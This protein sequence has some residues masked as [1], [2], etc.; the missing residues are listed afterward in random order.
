MLIEL[1]KCHSFFTS[2]AGDAKT[3]G[4]RSKTEDLAINQLDSRPTFFFL[5]KTIF[6]IIKERTEQDEF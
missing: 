5:S 3:A 1:F 2:I 4:I 6:I